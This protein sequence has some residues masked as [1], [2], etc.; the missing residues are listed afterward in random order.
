MKAQIWC[1]VAIYVLIAIVKKELRLDP[2][3]YLLLQ[4]RRVDVFEGGTN[5]NTIGSSGA[6]RIAGHWPSSRRI[7]P[8]PTTFACT[9][10]HSDPKFRVPPLQHRDSQCASGCIQLAEAG[11]SR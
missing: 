1:A 7:T 6:W 4:A 5:R 10:A 2:S 8:V 3:L 9:L 11:L